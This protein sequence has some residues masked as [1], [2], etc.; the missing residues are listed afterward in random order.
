[1]SGSQQT[2]VLQIWQKKKNDKNDMY[3]FPVHHYTPKQNGS[4]YFPCI[5]KANGRLSQ[6]ILGT[7][8]SNDADDKKQ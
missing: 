4:P 3:V 8:R 6:E 5:D 1:M 2:V 7:L